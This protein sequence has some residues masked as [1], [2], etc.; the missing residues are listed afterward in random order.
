MLAAAGAAAGAGI[1]AILGQLVDNVFFSS[2]QNDRSGGQAQEEERT[3]V[4]QM[5]KQIERGQAPKSATRAEPGRV[6]GE[7]DH[8]NFGDRDALNADGTWK[9]GGRDLTN[10]E[11]DWLTHNGWKAPNQ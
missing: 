4:N 9:H 2:T 7:Q 11:R 1:G 10:G 8:I 6:R 3:S 5:N